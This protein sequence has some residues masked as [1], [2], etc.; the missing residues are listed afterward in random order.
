MKYVIALILGVITGT[1]IFVAGLIFNPFSSDRS[2]SP[3]SV[4]DAEVIALSFSNVPTE[5]I[6]TSTIDT[7]GWSMAC[8]AAS[9]NSDA[10]RTRQNG[11]FADPASVSKSGPSIMSKRRRPSAALS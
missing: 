1:A 3:L 4:T 2:L 5:S 7:P 9:P 6:S 11:T 10:E 8:R